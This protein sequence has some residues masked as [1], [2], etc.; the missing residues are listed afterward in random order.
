MQMSEQEIR[1][2]TEKRRLCRTMMALVFGLLL[3]FA[4]LPFLI[5]ENLSSISESQLIKN[6][7]LVFVLSLIFAYLSSLNA[8]YRGILKD[9][10]N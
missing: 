8:K 5:Y 2:I 6:V 10:S 7:I 3:A 9:Q 4:A 1:E